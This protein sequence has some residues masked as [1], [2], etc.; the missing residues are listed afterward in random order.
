MSVRTCMAVATA[1]PEGRYTPPRVGWDN[2]NNIG[3]IVELEEEIRREQLKWNAKK[4]GYQ[5]NYK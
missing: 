3:I 2:Q 4:K 1:A 5:R